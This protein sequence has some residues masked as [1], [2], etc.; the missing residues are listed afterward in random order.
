MAN[1]NFRWLTNDI[2]ASLVLKVIYKKDDFNEEY[3]VFNVKDVLDVVGDKLDIETANIDDL[4]NLLTIG[5]VRF[6]NVG[7]INDIIDIP[8]RNLYKLYN[9]GNVLG[10]DTNILISFNEIEAFSIIDDKIDKNYLI[11]S[12]LIS[13]ISEDLEKVM[14]IASEFSS[15]SMQ[16]KFDAMSEITFINHRRLLVDVKKDEFK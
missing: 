8:F 13:D 11:F 9:N 12:A 5:I 4:T 3:A 2:D 1:K 16:E 14:R 10:N 7:D 6:V 15:Y